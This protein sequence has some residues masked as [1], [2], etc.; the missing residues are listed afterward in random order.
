MAECP[1][2]G[3]PDL[4]IN[5]SWFLDNERVETGLTLEFEDAAFKR[6]SDKVVRMEASRL[7]PGS[8]FFFLFF[9]TGFLC[10]ALA[11]LELTL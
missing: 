5:P 4:K 9:E 8:F 3:F 6:G 10:G 11:V 2:P 1:L 7:N